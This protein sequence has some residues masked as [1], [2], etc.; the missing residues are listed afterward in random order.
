MSGNNATR[1]AVVGGARTPFV[2][3][4]TV[5]RK[6]PALDLAV[7]SVDGL[8]EKQQLDPRSV[9]ELVYG[10][11]VVDARIPHLARE[12][13][14]SS[15]LPSDVRALTVTNNCI[16]GTSAITAIC[17]S[18][19]GGRAD[20]GIAGGVDS[21]SNPAMLFWKAACLL[22]PSFATEAALQAGY[23]YPP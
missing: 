4:G 20:V 8:L 18:I 17:D 1:V 11:T 19:A 2:K 10:I 9:D 13:V 5:F 23:P 12:V 22:K 3:A 14:F 16:T 6:Y 7:H 15:K 21:M